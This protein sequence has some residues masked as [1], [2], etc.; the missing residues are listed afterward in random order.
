MPSL[1]E[2]S[3]DRSSEEDGHTKLSGHLSP[4]TRGAQHVVSRVGYQRRAAGIAAPETVE[5]VVVREVR[6]A[7]RG[8]KRVPEPLP[9][10][11]YDDL[12]VG[13]REVL[14]RDD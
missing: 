12:T 13:R 6:L 9:G 14:K 8:T 1:R 2:Q 7:N 3:T 11:R 10:A 5:T 4:V